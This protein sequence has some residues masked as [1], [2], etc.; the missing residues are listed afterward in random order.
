MKTTVKM[1]LGLVLLGVTFTGFTLLNS[2]RLEK[3][4]ENFDE[5][6]VKRINVIEKD[7]TIRMVIS[8]KELQ[9]SGR[10]DGKD[11]EKRERQAGM[12]F[13]ND[14]GDECGGFVYA[15][16]KKK[17]GTITSGMSLTYDKYKNDQ[18]LQILNSETYKD[19]K[20]YSSRGFIVNDYQSD[21]VNLTQYSKMLKDAEKIAD[22]K[23]RKQKIREIRQ[24]YG[25][26][27]LLFLG[28]GSDSQGLF[29][30]DKN[31][32]PKLMIYVNEKGEPKIQTMNE[33]GEVKDFLIMETTTK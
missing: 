28:K 4:I 30:N 1:P 13:F 22:E 3:K 12:I 20:S 18:V 8:N 33:K 31:G 16:D 15:S 21:E 26:K 6:N 32:Q 23:E 27:N 19:G 29:I 24:K 10:M 17:D 7:G 5:I 11:W 14:E 9:H 25:S 2:F